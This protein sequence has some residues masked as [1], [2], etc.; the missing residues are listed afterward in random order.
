MARR[1]EQEDARSEVTELAPNVLRMELPIS[2][3]GLGHVNCYA[4]CDDDGVALI[5]PGLPTR[6]NYNALKDRL[7]QAGFEPRHVHHVL[8]THSHPDHFG[9]AAR[10]ARE[11]GAKIVAHGAFHIG[12]IESHRPEVSVEDL[13][14][15]EADDFDELEDGEAAAERR[16][17]AASIPK[18]RATT[19]ETP[20]G[21]DRPRPPLRARLRWLAMRYVFRRSV[22]PHIDQRVHAG[23]VL[24]FAKREWF[25]V[26]TP[27]HTEDHICLHCP[28]E[29]IF[30]AGDHV[31]PSITPHISGIAHSP[32]PLAD[33]YDSLDQ[34]AAIE[35]VDRVIPAHGH[36]F[37]DLA[38]RCD[39]IKRH[40]DE[41]LERVMEIARSD[42]GRAAR[43]SEFSK[44]LFRKRSW[45]PMADSETYAHVEHLRIAGK[46]DCRIDEQGHLVYEA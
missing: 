35:H 2:M 19:G 8:I 42:I 20:W 12:P 26:H 16:R 13:N 6:D 17:D 38:D 18:P 14:A 4:L 22:L 33:F 37:D 45:G 43:V 41:R 39:A 7:K 30:A 34:V 31:L 5:D 46:L 32:D 24:R 25:V 1:Q 44:F 3:P 36:P 40:H 15:Q 23:D 27:G 28:E 9:G 21:G 29:G 11:S 10:L